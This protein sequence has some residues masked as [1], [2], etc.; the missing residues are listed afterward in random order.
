MNKIAILTLYN[1]NNNYGGLAQAYALCKYLNDNGFQAEILNYRKQKGLS[2]SFKDRLEAQV[3]STGIRGLVQKGHYVASWMINKKLEASNNKKLDRYS[4]EIETRKV[5]FREFR[6]MTPHSK[7]YT[8]ETIVESLS[9]YDTFISGSDQIWKPG[10]IQDAFVLKFVT[11]HKKKVSYATSI[12]ISG[13]QKRAWFSKYLQ[14]NLSDYNAISVR[15]RETAQELRRVLKREV[16][17]VV[18][19]TLLLEKS[20]WD[21]LVAKRIVEGRYLFAY[22][23]GKSEKQREFVTKYAKKH[24]LKIVNL[25]FAGGEYVEADER[26]GDYRLFDIGLPEFF[27]LIKYAEIV[28]TDSFHAVCFSRVFE[29]NFYVM[30]RKVQSSS[31]KM[32]SRIESILQIMGLPSRMISED[33]NEC[34][35][36]DIDYVKVEENLSSYIEHSKQFLTRALLN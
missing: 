4:T 10:V 23:L 3:S 25:P 20:E 32:N 11:K 29:K 21:N 24:G 9:E 7:E 1:N 13:I 34:L 22:F 5:K 30:D 33:N 26:F 12:A 8:S 28:F 31:D 6:D 27:S 15:E 2:G 18:D 16:S 17:W 35:K 36:E 19:P 14:D